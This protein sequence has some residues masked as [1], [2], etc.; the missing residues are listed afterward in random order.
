MLTV[1]RIKLTPKDHGREMNPDLF[2]KLTGDPDY[3]FE[4]IDGRVYVSPVPDLPADG[5][6]VW[7][8]E[9]FVLYKVENPGVI[10]YVSRKARVFTPTGKTAPRPEPDSGWY[11]ESPKAPPEQDRQW[12][13]SN[14]FL[15]VEVVAESDPRK[16][17]VGN[18]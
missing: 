9:K 4:L 15:V 14:P 1:T 18:V 5:L 6:E 16:N 2:E 12:M 10:G 8:H 13:R 7:L 11:A 17:Y 3:H